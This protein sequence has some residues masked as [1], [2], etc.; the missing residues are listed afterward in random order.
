MKTPKPIKVLSLPKL[1]SVFTANRRSLLRDP[2]ALG[3]P[4]KKIHVRSCA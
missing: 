3:R 4:W 1:S 2:I